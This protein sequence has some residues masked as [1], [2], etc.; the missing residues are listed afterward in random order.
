MEKQT[1]L[2]LIKYYTMS[3]NM[4]DTVLE[5][6]DEN[7]KKTTLAAIEVFSNTISALELLIE[8]HYN[9]EEPLEKD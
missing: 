9:V 5:K 8:S 1:V 6:Q 2:E 7:L 3:K 4:A